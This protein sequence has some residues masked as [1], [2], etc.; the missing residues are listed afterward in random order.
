[1]LKLIDPTDRSPFYRMRGTYRRPGSHDKKRF[2]ESTKTPNKREAEKIL[3]ARHNEIQSTFMEG[4]AADVPFD[5]A[6]SSFFDTRELAGNPITGAQRDAILGRPRSGGG[7]SPC[8]ITD[9]ASTPVKQI[10]QLAV[11]AVIKRRYVRSRNSKPYAAGTI[12]R[13]FI[14]P[15]TAVLNFAYSQKWCDKPDFARPKFTD[16]RKRWATIAE[17]NRLL[18]A[19]APHL[20]DLILFLTLTGAREGEALS[21][22]WCDLDLDRAW[23]VIR[24]TKR[25]NE[26]RG[27]PLHPQVV[28][29]LRGLP[30]RT[31]KVFLTDMG[32]PYAAVADDA[33]DRMGSPIKTAWRGACRRARIDNLRPHD[34][35][36]TFASWLEGADVSSRVQEEIM[37]H[38][39]QRMNGRYAHIADAK[40]IA[41][42]E[43]L[44]RL[45]YRR[46]TRTEWLSAVQPKTHR[47]QIAA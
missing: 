18:A 13:Q 1:M 33:G 17:A 27:I 8:L 14:Q 12:V 34:L 35:R 36:H 24:N 45:D 11:N 7:I 22:D 47:R 44:P 9:F 46:I 41:A 43:K 10:D 42:I 25:N 26:D 20:R 37:G 32:L 6:V 3:I 29:A 19:S 30:R 2:D 40:L 15:L 31:G 21:L 38:V 4:R 39:S 5:L 23:A 28:A 16:K